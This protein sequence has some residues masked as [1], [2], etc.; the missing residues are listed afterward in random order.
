MPCLAPKPHVWR[1]PGHSEPLSPSTTLDIYISMVVRHSNLWKRT[2]PGVIQL[3]IYRHE[4][5]EVKGDVSPACPT[6]DFLPKRGYFY[7]KRKRHGLE[8]KPLS[9]TQTGEVRW[10]DVSL[11]LL[12]PRS[13]VIFFSQPCSQTSAKFYVTSRKLVPTCLLC[14]C[15][16]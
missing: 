5:G 16:N 1:S 4:A 10:Q 11:A 13:S 12:S 6:F 8:N 9:V 7:L 14:S 2:V 3:Q 15:G